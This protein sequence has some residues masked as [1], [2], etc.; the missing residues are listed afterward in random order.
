MITMIQL[1]AIK[2]LL[3]TVTL[4]N[5]APV[6]QVWLTQADAIKFGQSVAQRCEESLNLVGYRL[7]DEEASTAYNRDVFVYYD[8]SDFIDVTNP[9]TQAVLQT[10]EP[11]YT[12]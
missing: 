6:Q 7:K 4:K 11:V 2:Q 10:L 8:V 12:K 5:Q 1:N 3:P 9:V